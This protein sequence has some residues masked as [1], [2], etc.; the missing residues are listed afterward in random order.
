[1]PVPSKLTPVA[2]TSPVRAIER[3]VANAV[4][5]AERFT[6]ISAVPSKLTPPIVRDVSKAVAVPAF[7]LV[8]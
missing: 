6:A 1:M 3:A 5:V 4:A 2:V 8:F 7:P